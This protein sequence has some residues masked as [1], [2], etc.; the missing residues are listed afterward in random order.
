MQ[1][2]SLVSP[3]RVACGCPSNSSTPCPQAT[4]APFVHA[5]P[6]LRQCRPLATANP[7]PLSSPT[8]Q[9]VGTTASVGSGTRSLS[10]AT[11][12][13]SAAGKGHERSGHSG[14]SAGGPRHGS[15]QEDA[16][17]LL[18]S[19]IT[20]C[21]TTQQLGSLLRK[22]TGLQVPGA[23]SKRGQGV[24]SPGMR[25]SS[26]SSSSSSSAA[27]ESSSGDNG[28]A[29]DAQRYASGVQ[30][31]ESLP[32]AEGQSPS[33]PH[34]PHVP[35]TDF[36][37]SA[38][39][40]RC[41]TLANTLPPA[42]HSAS[43]RQSSNSG[44]RLSRRE[45]EVAG[46][47]SGGGVGDVERGSTAW[48]SLE[49]SA[50]SPSSQQA[51]PSQ[52]YTAPAQLMLAGTLARAPSPPPEGRPQLLAFLTDFLHVSVAGHAG[53]HLHLL[54]ASG[55]V[56]H[57]LAKGAGAHSLAKGV[58]ANSLVKGVVAQSLAKGVVEQQR[59]LTCEE[60]LWGSA[61]APWAQGSAAAGRHMLLTLKNVV[62][63]QVLSTGNPC[64][65]AHTCTHTHAHAHTCTRTHMHTH[66]YTH[67][68]AH[69]CTHTH[70]RAHTC[71]HTHIHIHTR[72]R[73]HSH[74]HTHARSPQPPLCACARTNA[75]VH[76]FSHAN[77]LGCCVQAVHASGVL[78][79]ARPRHA[80]ICIW[81]VARAGGGSRALPLPLAH[82]LLARVLGCA[83]PQQGSP[84]TV[85]HRAAGGGE[86]GVRLTPQ[87]VS[88][89]VWGLAKVHPALLVQ[90]LP[91]L[92]PLLL[93]SLPS[94]TAAQVRMGVR[95]CVRACVCARVR[96]GVQGH[97]LAGLLHVLNHASWEG[98]G[99]DPCKSHS[100]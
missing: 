90:E 71:M 50:D 62:V 54:T 3:T 98:R 9:P 53:T 85:D 30:P 33:A 55:L 26:S 70:K 75:N 17:R 47:S 37:V 64:T 86:P 89:A 42:S 73:T 8:A 39:C 91:A 16:S 15:A 78:A 35:L 67:T 100:M 11:T 65:R 87:A 31:A 24:R 80:A 7:A 25:P 79:S 38:V 43:R 44:G 51:L 12:K 34:P 1:R 96:T 81:A 46:S 94:M 83:A 20:A 59:P 27:T 28:V 60:V 84:A 66:T 49:P 19:R 72:T 93:R 61:G 22:S 21:T 97:W 99:V 14:G 18:T 4:C 88:N 82:M 58:V 45:G 57:S 77:L 6:K 23:S 10:Q 52:H 68:R 13:H 92:T 5:W 74:I 40:V 41:A 63:P 2:G 69:T 29:L 48:R 36:H 56:A 95:A 76:T 32:G